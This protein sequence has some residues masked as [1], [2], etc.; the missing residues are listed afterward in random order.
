M[1][2]QRKYMRN[3]CTYWVQRNQNN[4][5]LYKIIKRPAIIIDLTASDG[6]ANNWHQL[7]AL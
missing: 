5:I 4:G 7:L 2:A 1:H 6:P 3:V